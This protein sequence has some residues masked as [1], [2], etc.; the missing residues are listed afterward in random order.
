MTSKINF[1]NHKQEVIMK[2]T[3]FI[4][5][6]IFIVGL[7]ASS[8]FAWKNG[9]GGQGS[10]FNNGDWPRFDGQGFSSNLTQE[11]KDGLSKLHQKFIDETYELRS[12]KMVKRSQFRMLMAT[13]N[14][15]RAELKKM[16]D[17]MTEL[18]KKLRDKQIDYRL[19]AKKIAP[20]LASGPFFGNGRGG[21][22]ED[23]GMGRGSFHGN[24]GCTNQR[25][26]NN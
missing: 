6:T 17:E 5:S 1:K 3:I 19:E 20:E 7:I 15:D 12:E 22:R 16:S 8:S 9:P 25:A 13:S 2:K 11:Q 18:Q 24:W 10:R 14:P 23:R 4:I 26:F 21:W